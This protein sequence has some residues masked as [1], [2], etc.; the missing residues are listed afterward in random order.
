MSKFKAGDKVRILDGSK[1][2]DYTGSWTNSMGKFVGKV[3]TIERPATFKFSCG[4]T[5][6]FIEELIGCWDE[7]YLEPVTESETIVIYRK[8][9][10]VIALD[11]R[12]GKK[13]VA[14]CSPE[15]EFD[16]KIGAELAFKR[17]MAEPPKFKI[18][19]YVVANKKA[20]MY[21]GITT[22]GWRGV[23]TEVDLP[24]FI[25]VKELTGSSKYTVRNE[26]FDLSEAGYSGKV[27]CVDAHDVFFTRGKIYAIKNGII[28]DDRGIC[29]RKDGFIKSASDKLLSKYGNFI[30]LVE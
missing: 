19:D 5:A 16:F 17:L 12:T 29:R 30:E 1:A 4:R 7:K 25:R 3:V 6:Y 10:E 18:G 13:A 8:G 21:Y 9:Q 11:K 14:K 26:C 28:E 22:E 23:V 15:D 2:E 27:I 20:N 24:K